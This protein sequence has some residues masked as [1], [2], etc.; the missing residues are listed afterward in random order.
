M[1][2]EQL[3]PFDDESLPFLVLINSRGQYSLWP[4][5]TSIPPGWRNVLGPARRAEC[6]HYIEQN[7]TDIRPRLSIDPA[8]K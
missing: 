6:L 5:F 4:Q 1:N 8:D 2:T 7:W 3:N